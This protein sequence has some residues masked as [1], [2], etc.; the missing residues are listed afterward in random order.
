MIDIFKQTN[1]KIDYKKRIQDYN[2]GKFSSMIRADL[3][4]FSSAKIFTQPDQNIELQVNFVS[5]GKRI[6]EDLN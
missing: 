5:G 4:M 1:R 3:D 6:M 2:I